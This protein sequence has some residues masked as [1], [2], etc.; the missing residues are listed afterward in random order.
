MQE[1]EEQFE[2]F[3]SQ[4]KARYTEQEQALNELREILD[5]RQRHLDTRQ[6]DIEEQKREQERQ[7][8]CLDGVGKAPSMF[9]FSVPSGK[10]NNPLQPR[11][12]RTY[13]SS[14]TKRRISCLIG[15]R[16]VA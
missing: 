3:R 6:D 15:S 16:I 14:W 8:K 12:S 13:A 1:Q 5:R 9:L 11:P 7:Q 10:V 2:D 4:Q